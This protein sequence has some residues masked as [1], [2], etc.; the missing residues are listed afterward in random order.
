[1]TKR[2]SK[3]G[4]KTASTQRNYIARVV[5]FDRGIPFACSYKRMDAAQRDAKRF[6]GILLD[7]KT[8]TY[9]RWS[10]YK[11]LFIEVVV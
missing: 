3:S 4:K 8:G 5:G 6:L 1:M 9:H 7:L 11:G 10:S 2:A